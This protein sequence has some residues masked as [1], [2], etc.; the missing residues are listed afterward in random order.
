[1]ENRGTVTIKDVSERAGVAISTVSRVLNGLDRV[2]DETRDRV[3]QA[4]D[5]LG[6]V[7]NSLAA[8]MKTGKSRLVVVIV[9]DIINEFFTSVIKGVEE[10]AAANSYYTV[11]FSTN[12]SHHKENELFTGELGHIIDGAVIVP[13]NNN[14]QYYK[15]LDIP[16][17]I[18][19]R[20][21]AHSRMPAVVINNYKGGYLATRELLE[22]GH[23]NIA[24]LS[25]AQEFNIGLDRLGG[26]R[27]AMTAYG[28]PIRPENVVTGSWDQEFGYEQTQRLLTRSDPPTA[29]FAANNLLCVGCVHAARELGL[30]IGGDLSLV[31]FDDSFLAEFGDPG[32][33]VVRRP[34]VEMGRMGMAKLMELIQHEKEPTQPRKVVLDVELIRR[35]SVAVQ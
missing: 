26:Y 7:R 34:T 3:R 9:P 16:V 35:H 6:Y 17:V 22:A 33:T 32:V 21:V 28:V 1:M 11:V 24:L 12:D 13:A 14:L 2:S 25:G 18:V 23:Q 19:D 29:I 10:M 20:Y 5:D 8:S 4:A 15:A 27:D 31:G 30:H